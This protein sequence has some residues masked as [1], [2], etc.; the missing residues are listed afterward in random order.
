MTIPLAGEAVPETGCRAPGNRDQVSSFNSKLEARPRTSVQR[1]RSMSF[2]EQA[3]KFAKNHG[4]GAP[5]DVPANVVIRI[6]DRVALAFTRHPA[7]PAGV[8]EVVQ[9]N[10]K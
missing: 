10:F 9:R 6:S 1:R 3:R 8:P 7:E 5:D 4:G 2:V